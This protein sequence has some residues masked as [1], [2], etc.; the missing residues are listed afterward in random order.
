MWMAVPYS[1]TKQSKCSSSY[2]LQCIDSSIVSGIHCC[3]MCQRNALNKHDY[4]RG[5]V[6]LALQVFFSVS[7]FLCGLGTHLLYA[8]VHV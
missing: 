8:V 1:S 2:K 7:H 5:A 3:F 6:S 4:G